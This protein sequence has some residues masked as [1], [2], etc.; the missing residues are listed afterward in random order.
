MK[1]RAF[2]LASMGALA[3]FTSLAS[4][5]C[6]KGAPQQARCKRCGMRVDPAS[7]WRTDLVHDDGSVTSFD[8]PRCALTSWRTGQT[9]AKAIRVQEYYD[10][11]WRD[12]AE[13]RFLYGG[14]VAGPMGPDFVPVDPSRASKFIQ[15]HGAE[16][17]YRL[18][19]LTADFLAKN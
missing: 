3:S 9:P 5:A 2:L 11:A 17:A 6:K 1:R 14:D 4:L 12:G 7:S 18:D 13:V 15:D 8:T 16:A 10:R 19:E